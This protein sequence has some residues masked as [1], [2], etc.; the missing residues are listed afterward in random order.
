MNLKIRKC[1]LAEIYQGMAKLLAKCLLGVRLES[2]PGSIRA[3]GTNLR[4]VLI[5]AGEV[6]ENGDGEGTLVVPMSQLKEMATAPGEDLVVSNTPG[7]GENVIV[8]T[9][10]RG[11]F[12][13]CSFPH[14]EEFP[15]IPEMQESL[16][17]L[18]RERFRAEFLSASQCTSTTRARYDLDCIALDGDTG[19]M[20]ATDGC[21]LYQVSGMEFPWKGTCYLPVT[22]HFPQKLLFAEGQLEVAKTENH[23]VFRNG[24]WTYFAQLKQA[25]F[26]P[27]EK[28]S[29]DIGDTELLL[30]VSE[31]DA[32]LLKELLP[33]MPGNQWGHR[34]V[35]MEAG[36]TI[37]L[38]AKSGGSE[39]QSEARLDL[40]TSHW[41]GEVSDVGFNR[42]FLVRA[43]EWGFR[44]FRIFKDGGPVR[45]E[46]ANG[47]YL[48]M[49][50]TLNDPTPAEEEE[51]EGQDLQ[52]VPE[53]KEPTKAEI[54]KRR[55]DWL[56]R[57]QLWLASELAAGL[58]RIGF[59][60]FG[61]TKHRIERT[62]D[63]L[64][65]LSAK[66]HQEPKNGL[67]V[68]L[69]PVIP[70]EWDPIGRFERADGTG[71]ELVLSKDGFFSFQGEDG[72]DIRQADVTGILEP[73]LATVWRPCHLPLYYNG[74]RWWVE[75]DH[76]IQRKGKTVKRQLI[77]G[78]ARPAA[79]Q[80]LDWEIILLKR[81]FERSGDSLPVP[82]QERLTQRLQRLQKLLPLTKPQTLDLLPL[83][84]TL[85]ASA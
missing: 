68:L 38:Q 35:F 9:E 53:K 48:F 5:Y 13:R 40:A 20:S 16:Q 43:L 19:T 33:Q 39:I 51:D 62:H 84:L 14:E 60:G 8:E 32:G 47:S 3:T 10:S 80:F 70:I 45:A 21:Q 63:R 66:P 58:D 77:F 2:T 75:A 29:F 11:L 73:L 81:L 27:I 85:P 55:K 42:E 59:T 1:V 4:D 74:Q 49:R 23:L 30:I 37:G 50:I 31:E 44:C 82:A 46:S 24:P 15:A 64:L 76:R 6:P 12:W 78:E 28:L 79:I 34:E 52:V 54:R 36:D 71:V 26:P 83:C 7:E 61:E 72:V 56:E 22:E 41:M 65:E 67:E 57:E 17:T 25:S 18:D 69:P